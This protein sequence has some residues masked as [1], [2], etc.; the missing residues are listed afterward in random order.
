M[1]KIV[2]T[3]TLIYLSLRDNIFYKGC[4]FVYDKAW[5]DY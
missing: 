4:V 3:M 1:K 5:C 2:C